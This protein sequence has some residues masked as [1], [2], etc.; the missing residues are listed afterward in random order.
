MGSIIL[1]LTILPNSS[2][3]YG[4]KVCVSDDR[5]VETVIYY[6]L[7]DKK[8]KFDTRKSGLS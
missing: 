8:L 4:I 6:D 3:Q 2:T 7:K 5:H 1:E